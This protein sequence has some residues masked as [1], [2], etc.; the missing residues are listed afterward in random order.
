MKHAVVFS[1]K[2]NLMWLEKEEQIKNIFILAASTTAKGF[3]RN[4]FEKRFTETQRAFLWFE[5]AG[6]NWFSLL[7]N[8]KQNIYV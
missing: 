3:V 6:S 1:M 7:N 2:I 5:S 4:S 8:F